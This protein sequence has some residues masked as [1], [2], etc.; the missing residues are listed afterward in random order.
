VT[1]PRGVLTG[2]AAQRRRERWTL[3]VAAGAV[4]FALSYASQRLVSL[5]I[6]EPTFAEV[7]RTAHT[8]LFWR[9]AIAATQAAL[10]VPLV[11]A[12]TPEVMVRALLRLGPLWVIG[13]VMV[14]ALALVVFP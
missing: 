11:A 13:P 9:T 7:L 10:A 5:L 2:T 1:P 6:G 14:F 8:P 12:V 4:V 3:G